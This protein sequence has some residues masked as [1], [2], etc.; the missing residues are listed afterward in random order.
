M[1]AIKLTFIC[2]TDSADEHIEILLQKQ[3]GTVMPDPG[4]IVSLRDEQKRRLQE[5]PRIRIDA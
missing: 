3:T 4:A 5:N 1:T 2:A